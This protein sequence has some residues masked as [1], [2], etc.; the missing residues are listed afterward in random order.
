MKEYVFSLKV[1][2]AVNANIPP[3]FIL[4][5]ALCNMLCSIKPI[6]SQPH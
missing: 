4:G 5:V 6:Y 2:N 1:D 3:V